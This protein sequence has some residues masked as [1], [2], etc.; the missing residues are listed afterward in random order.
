MNK[1]KEELID[2]AATAL[3][4]AMVLAAK[5]VLSP[6]EEEG[7]IDGLDS[8]ALLLMTLSRLLCA[9]AVGAGIPKQTLMFG[10][11]ETF[12]RLQAAEEADA[13]MIRIARGTDAN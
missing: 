13:L 8:I 10:V 2:Q 9:S 7:R 1:Q 12:D 11:S 3:N 4:N 5:G 6:M